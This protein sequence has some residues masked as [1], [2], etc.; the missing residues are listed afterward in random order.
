[1]C[2]EA[3]IAALQ[4]AFAKSGYESTVNGPHPDED[5]PLWID[6]RDDYGVQRTIWIEDSKVVFDWDES[7]RDVPLDPPPVTR[8]S[9]GSYVTVLF[10]DDSRR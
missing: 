7:H 1:M 10:C 4:A 6:V 9:A 2:H 3:I 8:Y 5:V